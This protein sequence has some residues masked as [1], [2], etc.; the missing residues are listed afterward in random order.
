MSLVNTTCGSKPD[1]VIMLLF[2]RI[3]DNMIINMIFVHS[4]V[5]SRVI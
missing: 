1:V 2:M 4:V 5:V 3:N